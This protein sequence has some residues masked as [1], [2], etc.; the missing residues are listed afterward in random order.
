MFNRILSFVGSV[1]TAFVL[2]VYGAS[3]AVMVVF[4]Y[5]A[6]AFTQ[7]YGVLSYAAFMLLWSFSLTV[8]NMATLAYI[9]KRRSKA[10]FMVLTRGAGYPF[11]LSGLELSHVMWYGTTAI[12]RNAAYSGPIRLWATAI[13]YIGS[14]HIA[15]LLALLMLSDFA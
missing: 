15:A 3:A 11:V 14:L 9:I 13:K 6:P 5:A 2:L 10:D 7:K 8:L 4:L 1:L 12:A